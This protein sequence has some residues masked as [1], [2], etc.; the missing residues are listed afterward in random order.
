MAPDVES[1]VSDTETSLWAGIFVRFEASLNGL[2]RHLRR[3]NQ[4]DTWA[5][6]IWHSLGSVTA[7]GAAGPITFNLGSPPPGYYWKVR[8][9]Q[10][11][12]PS[13]TAVASVVADVYVC[14]IALPPAGQSVA[15]NASVPS[16]GD[17]YTSSSLSSSPGSLPVE[18]TFGSDEMTL[19]SGDNLIVVLSG[20][21][22]TSATGQFILGGFVH[23]YQGLSEMGLS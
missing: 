18:I 20:A 13:A 11:T 7:P 1:P 2:S 14:S 23:Q 22:V 9:I 19:S 15:G 5:T 3:R 17:W 10:V 21:G 16:I 8:T 4:L 6:P 12:G